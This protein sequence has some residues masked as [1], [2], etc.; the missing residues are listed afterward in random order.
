MNG[1]KFQQ[2]LSAPSHFSKLRCEIVQ[3]NVA[4]PIRYN[5]VCDLWPQLEPISLSS[6]PERL[7]F[8]PQ[9]AGVQAEWHQTQKWGQVLLLLLFPNFGPNLQEFVP[10]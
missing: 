4:H 5:Q 3:V 1:F 2:D 10:I 9:P 7:K 6:S 8:Q